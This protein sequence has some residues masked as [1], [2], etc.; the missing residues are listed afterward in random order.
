MKKFLS[1]PSPSKTRLLG[2]AL[3]S[4]VV[5]ALYACGGGGG[6]APAPSP[7]P[8]PA[9]VSKLN[10][11]GITA[12]QC[13]GAGTTTLVLCSSAEARALSTAQD[14]MMGR[15][16]TAATNSA[17][18]GKLGFSYTKIA[19]DGSALPDSATSW[20]CV[21][22]NVTGLVW[23]VKTNDGGLRD[24]T[25]LY[26]NYDN[27]QLPQIGGTTNP[28]QAQIDAPTNSVGFKN[29]VNTATLCGAS[30]WRLPSVHEL[31]GLVDYG[32]APGTAMLD[33]AWFPN[34][35]ADLYWT[36]TQHA[37]YNSN[38]WSVHFREG[39]IQSFSR[40]PLS[41]RLVRGTPIPRQFSVS[42]N[43]QEVT[44]EV[45]GLIWRRCLEGQT[46]NQGACTDPVDILSISH[47][48][49]LA[50]AS[51]QASATGQ[52][53]RLPNAKELL[54][55]V[56]TRFANPALDPAL[57]PVPPQPTINYVWSATPDSLNLSSA[58]AVNMELGYSTQSSL[59]I[60]GVR[61]VRTKP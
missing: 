24:Y 34:S 35:V 20:S 5:A 44:H 31:S 22:D 59:D 11:T 2:L 17:A 56:D 38:A 18:D 27:I 6:G 16:A 60:G 32:A 4:G 25:K 61:L 46:L 9:T 57:F 29:A 45:N 15:D 1:T 42:S 26:T 50:R 3:L 30:D 33:T 53:W 23:E 43:G 12:S 21:R 52:A 40:S 14:G 55:I 54:S 13:F 51:A 39:E 49:A 28:T 19:A 37:F 58:W 41:V 8:P 36:S 48:A 10:D 7:V 47:S